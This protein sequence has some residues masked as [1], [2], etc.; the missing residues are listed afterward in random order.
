MAHII[1]G[2]QALDDLERI[3]EYIALDKP[4]AAVRLMKRVFQRVDALSHT[5]ES[6][7]AIPELPRGSRYRQVIVGPC[8]VLYR[9]N[10]STKTV[11]IIGVMRGEK[12]FQKALLM[13]RDIG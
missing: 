5:P 10:Q 13:E 9:Y 8:R 11:Y 6:G 3:A 7:P 2:E 12:L 1:W 4:D